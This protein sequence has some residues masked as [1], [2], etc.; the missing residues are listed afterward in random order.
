MPLPNGFGHT[1]TAT[2]LNV[3]SLDDHPGAIGQGNRA[4]VG[5]SLCSGW[6]SQDTFIPLTHAPLV[7]DLEWVG[8]ATDCL[9]TGNNG[10]LSPVDYSISWA[11]APPQIKCDI[12][13]LGSELQNTYAA[14]L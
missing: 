2:Q 8:N 12:V 4:I 3:N 13:S 6:F 9:N 7:I 1:D 5:V 11:T 14:H 10:A